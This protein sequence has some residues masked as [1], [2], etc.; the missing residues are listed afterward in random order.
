MAS[1]MEKLDAALTELDIEHE[2]IK[3]IADGDMIVAY[4]GK[5]GMKYLFDAICNEFSYGGRLGLIEVMGKWLIGRKGI[6]GWLTAE[7]VIELA[8]EKRSAE[9]E[10][11]REENC[12]SDLKKITK[13]LLEY[14]NKDELANQVVLRGIS[15]PEF[16]RFIALTTMAVNIKEMLEEKADI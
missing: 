7:D 13:E 1:E 10:K 9:D 5:S 4:G 8:R 11:V 6:R 16:M 2:C 14:A 12:V 15:D 3:D